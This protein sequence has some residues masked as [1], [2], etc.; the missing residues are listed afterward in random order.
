MRLRRTVNPGDT[1]TVVLYSIDKGL[2][3]YY[4]TM[5]TILESD[6]SPTLLAPAN[7]VT[8]LSAGLGYFT[9]YE[10][11]EMKIVLKK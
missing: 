4:S 10:V 8:N 1:V 2:Y 6:R 3:D 11:D 9:A 7:P 5:N